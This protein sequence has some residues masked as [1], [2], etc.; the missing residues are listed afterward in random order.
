M[1]ESCSTEL[2]LEENNSFYEL[3]FF[4]TTKAV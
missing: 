2:Y 3:G 1:E 4:E